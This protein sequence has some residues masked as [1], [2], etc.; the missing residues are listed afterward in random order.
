MTGTTNK[1]G[2]AHVSEFV[3]EDVLV[4]CRRRCCLCYFLD[5]DES[6]EEG[7][8][9]HLDRNASNA[10]EDNL[11]FLCIPHHDQ[12]DSVPRQSK[13]LTPAEVRHYKALLHKCLGTT[14]CR[15]KLVITGTLTP[16]AR[17][18]IPDILKD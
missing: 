8:I 1:R 10:S 17:E 5:A 14:R 9:A 3:N 11:V 4:R 6:V 2:R 13:R 18:K 15:V 16:E 7:L 12:Y